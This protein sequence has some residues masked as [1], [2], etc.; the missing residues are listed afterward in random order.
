MSQIDWQKMETEV[1]H[2]YT[3]P[4]IHCYPTK[5]KQTSKQIKHSHSYKI[6][7]HINIYTHTFVVDYIFLMLHK[8]VLCL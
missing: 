7:T 1:K 5:N 3:L 6:Y 8:H 2:L 4:F